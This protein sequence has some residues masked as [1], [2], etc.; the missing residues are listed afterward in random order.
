MTTREFRDRLTRRA[1]KQEIVLSPGVA[2]A[3]EKYF[4]L[5]ALWNSK[6][7]LTALR[8]DPPDEHTFDRLLIEP[9][10]AAKHLPRGV[11]RLMDVGSG[12]GSPAIPL[13]VAVSG[14]SV[15]MVE[16][17]TRKAV[18]LLEAVRH[19][20][21]KA[22]VETARFEQLLARPDLHEAMDVLTV[23]AVRVEPRTLLSLQAFI[24]PDGR[25][26]WFRSASSHLQPPGVPPPL[27]WVATHSLGDP[28][29]SRLVV[30]AKEPVGRSSMFHVEH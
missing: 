25:L 4:R 5:L 18:F 7:N 8:L 29:H 12:S 16:S 27:R 24:K 30:L 15:T 1:R 28:A 6:I 14:L 26:F 2:A 17:K 9:L 19:L 22:E 13:A 23:R 3:L 20:A 11:L 10:I 21:L